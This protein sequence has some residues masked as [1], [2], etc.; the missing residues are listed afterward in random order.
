M[1]EPT[2]TIV[3]P[4]F[5]SE[6]TIDAAIKSAM[7]QTHRDIELIVVDDG[8]TDSTPNL[9]S[10]WES[11]DPRVR[12]IRQ[13]NRG[14]AAAR[15]AALKLARGRLVGFLDSDDLWMPDYV[16]EVTAALDREPGAS[17]AY[18]DSWLYD[19]RNGRIRKLTSLEHYHPLPPAGATAEDFLTHLARMNFVSNSSTCRRAALEAVGGFDEGLV[20]AEDWDLW[21][22]LAAGAGPGVRPTHPLIINCDRRGSFSKNETLMWDSISEVSRRVAARDDISEETRSVARN[23]ADEAGRGHERVGAG[24]PLRFAR[25]LAAT[26]RRLDVTHFWWRDWRREPPPEVAAAFPELA[27]NYGKPA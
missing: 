9:I 4:A 26:K 11:R 20:A 24:G 18:P 25:R 22:R 13:A 6:R 16:A 23:A 17:F 7:A 1:N 5:N 12:A 8:S 15:N 14:P 2:F 21:L 10:A 3:M 19:E 27:A